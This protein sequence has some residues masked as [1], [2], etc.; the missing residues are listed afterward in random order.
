MTSIIVRAHIEQCFTD[1]F[2]IEQRWGRVLLYALCFGGLRPRFSR[3]DKSS[4]REKS[5]SSISIS[6]PYTGSINRDSESPGGPILLSYCEAAMIFLAVQDQGICKIENIA[7]SSLEK[8]FWLKIA[9]TSFL[10]PD[11]SR[12]SQ[13]GSP[14]AEHIGAINL[15]STRQL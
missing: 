7:E 5:N 13:R 9:W 10:H 12:V 14:H 2:F 6:D 3:L 4:L 11:P 8:G 1:C 15:R